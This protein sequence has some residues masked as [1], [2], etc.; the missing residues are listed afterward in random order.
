MSLDRFIPKIWSARLLQNLH[1]SHVFAQVANTNFEGEIANFGDTVKISGIGPVSVRDYT[2]GATITRDEVDDAQITLTI[3]QA[4]YFNFG[5][6]D[7][8]KAQQKPKVMDEAMREASYALADTSD[9]FMAEFAKEAHH[10][11]DAAAITSVDVYELLTLVNQKLDEQNVPRGARWGVISPWFLGKMVLAK[12]FQF[13]GSLD[14]SSTES[15]GFIGSALGINFYVSNNLVDD[16]GASDDTL[17]PFGTRRAIS[18]AEQILSIDAYRPE[19]S[20]ADAMK[21]L[22]VYG[23]KVVDPKSMVT[24]QTRFSAEA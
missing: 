19:D 21:G 20:F 15:S 14:V 3:D 10:T 23:G 1:K 22:H 4:K 13:Q 8:D 17:M 11:E 9:A 24:L 6:D 16:Y 2:R 12:L 18:Y 7:I 5:I